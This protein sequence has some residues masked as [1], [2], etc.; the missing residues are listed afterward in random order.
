MATEEVKAAASTMAKI[1][2]SMDMPPVERSHVPTI[3]TST[4]PD[5]MN[6]AMRAMGTETSFIELVAQLT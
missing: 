3:S 5:S 2:R 6:R 1:R 4:V